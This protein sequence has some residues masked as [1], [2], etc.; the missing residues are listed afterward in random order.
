MCSHHRISSEGYSLRSLGFAPTMA[1]TFL[2]AP[3]YERRP[4]ET[5]APRWW[6]TTLTKY[7][8]PLPETFLHCAPMLATPPLDPHP[9]PTSY[10]GMSE[11]RIMSFTL[12]L[13]HLEFIFTGSYTVLRSLIWTVL[14]KTK[15]LKRQSSPRV[16]EVGEGC[17][18]T[19]P[20]SLSSLVGLSPGRCGWMVVCK[21]G[22]PLLAKCLAAERAEPGGWCLVLLP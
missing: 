15:K 3:G 11:R 1:V 5:H 20:P 17:C 8:P 14:R 9:A 18:Q 22:G 2:V 16:L 13:Q 21:G 19:L 4:E 6:N 12:R 7:P 10:T